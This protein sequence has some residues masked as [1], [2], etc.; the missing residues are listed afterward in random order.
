LRP[1][2][3]YAIL[4]VPVAALC[5]WFARP[6]PAAARLTVSVAVIGTAG[7]ALFWRFGLTP[8]LRDELRVGVAKV[9]ARFG[10]GESRI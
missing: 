7:A 5:H 8:A 1:A 9:R 3:R 6:L 10:A 4:L 2:L